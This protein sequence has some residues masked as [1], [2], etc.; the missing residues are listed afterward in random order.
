MGLPWKLTTKILSSSFLFK[1]FFTNKKDEENYFP[2]YSKGKYANQTNKWML[3]AQTVLSTTA[4][5]NWNRMKQNHQQNRENNSN[6]SNS[7]L[8]KSW[9][10]ENWG[11]DNAWSVSL[12]VNYPEINPL[13][14]DVDYPKIHPFTAF[15]TSYNG[16]GKVLCIKSHLKSDTSGILKRSKSI[17]IVASD[18]LKPLFNIISADILHCS[19]TTGVCVCVCVCERERIWGGGLEGCFLLW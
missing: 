16:H 12:D 13:S 17:I 10:G 1:V 5:Q 3:F 19:L 8:S 6:N 2:R 7:Q 11:I 4:D 18:L 9:R 15:G 14:V